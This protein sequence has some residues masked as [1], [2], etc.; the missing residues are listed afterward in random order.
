[1]RYAHAY[2]LVQCERIDHALKIGGVGIKIGRGAPGG[3]H[4]LDDIDRSVVVYIHLFACF[5]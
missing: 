2:G 3:R 4:T 5:P 1:M